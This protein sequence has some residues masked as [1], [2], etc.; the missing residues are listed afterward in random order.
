MTRQ[1]TEPPL[2]E[3]WRLH[4]E[5]LRLALAATAAF[6]A[7]SALAL[8]LDFVSAA[9]WDAPTLQAWT[10]VPQV[11]ALAGLLFLGFRSAS[12]SFTVLAALLALVAIEEAFHVLNPIAAILSDG[13]TAGSHWTGFWLS[14]LVFSLIYGLVALIGLAMIF[15]SHRRGSVAERPVV[16]NLALMLVVGG[17]FGGPIGA[18]LSSGRIG[19]WPYVEELGEAVVFAVIAGYVA[20]LVA[21]SRLL[22]EPD[23]PRRP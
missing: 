10:L 17:L 6:L 15:L 13:A 22:S 19:R 8:G 11:L 2:I 21:Q 7:G 3:S 9:G 12:A 4:D 14:V 18:L 1:K 23:H 16:R 20:G 5:S